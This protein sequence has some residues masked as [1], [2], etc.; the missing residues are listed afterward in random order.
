MAEVAGSPEAQARL[1]FP[2]LSR[3]CAIGTRV[4]LRVLAK[5]YAQLALNRGFEAGE[6]PELREVSLHQA[7]AEVM[8]DVGIDLP[9]SRQAR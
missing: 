4:W 6:V 9:N 7:L 2:T 8:T 1:G 3:G 5:D